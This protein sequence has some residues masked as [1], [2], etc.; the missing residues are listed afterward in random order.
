MA[1]HTRKFQHPAG[2]I[3]SLPPSITRAR[4]RRGQWGPCYVPMCPS[5]G[6]C[7]LSSCHIDHNLH[8][9]LLATLHLPLLPTL[10][11]HHCG[12]VCMQ[13]ATATPRVEAAFPAV[14][15]VQTNWF[16]SSKHSP[17][18]TISIPT[19]SYFL[20]FLRLLTYSGLSVQVH[21]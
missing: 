6:C 11:L 20:E 12:L 9:P 15:N 3:P 16:L 4:T 13:S 1:R 21:L 7:G 17:P 10:H 14:T 19:S 5:M 18:D 2:H 8:L